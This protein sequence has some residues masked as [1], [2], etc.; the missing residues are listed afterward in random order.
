MVAIFS[1]FLSY[2]FLLY[3]KIPVLQVGTYF[4]Q[5]FIINIFRLF[6]FQ[7]QQWELYVLSRLGWDL[8]SVTP[9]DFLELLLIRLP[10]TSTKCPDLNVE[11]VRQHA[12]AFISLA[13][14]GKLI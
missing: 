12:Q 9:L 4:F 10:I 11:K 8:S 14:K 7:L 5:Y 1:F 6:S 2:L 13:A 3:K